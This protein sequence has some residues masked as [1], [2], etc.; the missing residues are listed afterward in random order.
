MLSI[1]F[2]A[3]LYTQTEIQCSFSLTY[4]DSV[5]FQIF[6][7]HGQLSSIQLIFPLR[8][9]G[10]PFGAAS[11]RPVYQDA[12][13]QTSQI[14]QV[15]FGRWNSQCSQSSSMVSWRQHEVAFGILVVVLMC[16]LM[17]CVCVRAF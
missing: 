4:H 5:A 2:L 12:T 16:I 8:P 3:R 6:A 13:D 1:Y 17:T 10:G 11:S 9:F 15:P 14:S 7:S